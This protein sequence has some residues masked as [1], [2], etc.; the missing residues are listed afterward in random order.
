MGAHKRH[1][2]L[3]TQLVRLGIVTHP[4]LHRGLP[5]MTGPPTDA[6]RGLAGRAVGG[7]QHPGAGGG[8]DSR[9]RPVDG[10]PSWVSTAEAP[11]GLRVLLGE[12]DGRTWFA[13]V[14]DPEDA[15][16]ERSEWLGL[17]AA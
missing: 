4:Q 14:V 7:S 9:I 10:R 6:P 8:R 15:P 13:V 12:R 3:R 2:S 5:P 16:G 17:R 1:L 11:D